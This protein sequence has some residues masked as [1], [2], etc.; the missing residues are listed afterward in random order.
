M[1][2]IRR[3]S[4]LEKLFLRRTNVNDEIL[5]I[6]FGNNVSLCTRIHTLDLWGCNHLS[7]ESIDVLIG[8]SNL[9]TLILAD[10]KVTHAK[11]QDIRS[12]FPLLEDFSL[13]RCPIE[14]FNLNYIFGPAPLNNLTNLDLDYLEGENL[15]L[16]RISE[17]CPN[18]KSL[19]IFGD[20]YSNITLSKFCRKMTS[21]TVLS[22]REC[23]GVA[24]NIFLSLFNIKKSKLRNPLQQL[25]LINC[26]NLTEKTFTLAQEM[27]N[28]YFKNRSIPLEKTTKKFIETLCFG[29]VSMKFPPSTHLFPFLELKSYRL[30]NLAHFQGQPKFFVQA[31]VVALHNRPEKTF[32]YACSLCLKK[33]D[34]KCCTSCGEGA[35]EYRYIL[36]MT[37]ADCSCSL[38]VTAF[39]PVALNLM[40]LPAEDFKYLVEEE[41]EAGS[42]HIHKNVCMK[43]WQF[44]IVKKQGRYLV[45]NVFPV[46]HVSSSYNLF[47]NI[48][49]YEVK[50]QSLK[51]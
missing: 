21:L 11:M 42:N 17:F 51:K 33:R 26:C 22:I 41:Q 20:G 23:V 10:T 14:I 47:D 49:C 36:N 15:L 9:K 24:D 7:D 2:S 35:G 29:E 12:S 28:K 16:E 46:D 37:I 4:T 44:L 18:L 50:S 34:E 40:S 31:T 13:R 25:S 5:K 45:K 39:E 27:Y 43:A 30:I 38:R 48:R 1:C 32:Y 3:C 19:F 8:C 6:I